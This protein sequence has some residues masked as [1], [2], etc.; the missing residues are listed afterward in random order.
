MKTAFVLALAAVAAADK[1][2]VRLNRFFETNTNANTESVITAPVIVKVKL[3]IAALEKGAAASSDPRQFVYD[4]LTK[5][6]E[7][8]LKTLSGV[9]DVK[10]AKP[11][12]IGGAFYLPRA[13]KETVDKLSASN[14][15][16][17]L[18]LNAADVSFEILKN[19]KEAVREAGKNEW[20]VETVGA[21]SIWKYYNGT[22]AV[23]GSI[24]TGAMYTHEAIKNNWR[25]ELGWFD[26]YNATSLPW[27]SYGHGSHTIGTMVGSNGIGVAPG[28]KWIACMGLYGR[29]GDDSSLL[30]CAQFMLCPTK[31]DGTGADC[32]KGPHV[33]NNSW[34]STSFDPWYEDA[35]AAWKAAG[36]IPVFSNGNNGPAC[37]TVG[38]PGGYNTVIGV[39]A[40]GSYDSE[41]NLIAY[42]SSK[43]PQTANGPA[44]IKPDVSAPGFWTR[45]VD[46]TTNSS[47][48]DNAGTSM[49]APHVSGVVA[50]LKS[51]D[52]SL[53]YDKIYKYLTAT[54]DQSPLNT[55]E[56]TTWYYGAYRN[57]TYPGA[58]NCGDVKDTAWPNNRFGHGRVNVGTIL[59]DGTLHDTR[60]SSC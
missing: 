48:V 17:Y 6:S 18:D 37:G 24:D 45:S 22:G 12:W 21:P 50:I 8:N 39:G 52:P 55:T 30:Q 32:K 4:F 13:T 41:P 46:I 35:V 7:E 9:V 15:V 11:L 3:D 53:S 2:A 49:A 10:D 57:K 40:I 1:V 42:F 33:V 54:T 19:D 51:V 60:R 5:A 23:V 25:S 20:G 31:P 34:G 14:S 38:N 36:I 16:T 27:D 43:G 58:P 29:N 44:Y 28:A 26:P 59:R 56:P 47:Y